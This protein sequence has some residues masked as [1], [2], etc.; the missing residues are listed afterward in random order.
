[1]GQISNQRYLRHQQ[2]QDIMGEVV[3]VFSFGMLLLEF[4]GEIPVASREAVVRFHSDSIA[5][6]FFFF[7]WVIPHELWLK[8]ECGVASLLQCYII[9]SWKQRAG[10]AGPVASYCDII[11]KDSIIIPITL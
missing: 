2:E 11:E 10:L 3:V 9:K 1:M 6:F 8:N 5:L 4:Y 7:F